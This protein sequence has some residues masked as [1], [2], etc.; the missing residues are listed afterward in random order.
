MIELNLRSG[1]NWQGS[2]KQE[3]RR[4]KSLKQGLGKYQD[5]HLLARINGELPLCRMTS[6]FREAIPPLIVISESFTPI[7]QHR[8]EDLKS[9]LTFRHGASSI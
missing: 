6:T 7:S 5:Y 4:T 8:T 9:D 1:V 2:L 3:S